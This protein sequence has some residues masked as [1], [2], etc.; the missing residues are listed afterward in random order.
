MVLCGNVYL[1][2]TAPALARK[3]MAVATYIVATESLGEERARALIGNNAAV[4]DMN[5]VLDYYRRSADHRLLF[6]GRVSYS[7]L[8]SFDAPSATRARMLNVFPSSGCAHRYAWGGEVDITLNRARTSDAS[9][10][11]SI[12]CRASPATASRS[13]A[14]PA[15]ARPR[16]SGTAER[17]DVFA[18]IPHANFP[19]GMAL[20]APGPGAGDALLSAQDLLWRGHPPDHVPQ[21]SATASSFSRCGSPGSPPG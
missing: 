6:G 12:S 7:G 20:H 4:S 2:A 15:T 3:I 21:H 19:G 5:W 17:F 11:T 9:R 8:K 18:R 16:R 13:R 1:G 14:S 10:P